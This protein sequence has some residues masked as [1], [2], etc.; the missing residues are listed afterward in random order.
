MLQEL[1]SK[2]REM[3]TCEKWMSSK[4]AKDS[5]GKMTTNII[6]M[7]SF[8]SDVVYTLKVTTSLVDVLRMVDNERK[9][10]MSYIYAAMG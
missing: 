4:C 3:F 2:L 10:T 8:W 1:K 7:A 5:K 9:H 6:L